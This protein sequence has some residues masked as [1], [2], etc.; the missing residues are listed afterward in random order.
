VKTV[1]SLLGVLAAAASVVACIGTP[2]LDVI[3]Q[4]RTETMPTSA[5]PAGGDEAKAAEAGA[6]W[7]EANDASD[8]ARTTAAPTEPPSRPGDEDD[9]DDDRAAPPPS[10]SACG[11]KTCATGQICCKGGGPPRCANAADG[12]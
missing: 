3:R 1:R 4:T 7:T 6:S 5:E 10:G 12:C 9:D 2:E 11:A 8:A